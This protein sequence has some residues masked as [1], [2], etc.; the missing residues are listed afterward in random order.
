MIKFT[1]DHYDAVSTIA[2]FLICVAIAWCT[3]IVPAYPTKCTSCKGGIVSHS[4][5]VTI[6]PDC[7]GSAIL[8]PEGK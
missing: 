4:G 2:I 8:L 7:H 1:E 3:R 5:Y 6:C